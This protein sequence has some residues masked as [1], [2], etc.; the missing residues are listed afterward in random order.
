L[1][2]CYYY[3]YYYYYWYYYWLCLQV[4]WV[5]SDS[6]FS[7]VIQ[8]RSD[9][10][11][12]ST[13]TTTATTFPPDVKLYDVLYDE[14]VGGQ[15]VQEKHVAASR[16]RAAAVAT[17]AVTAAMSV[18]QTPIQKSTGLLTTAPVSKTIGRTKDN[19]KSSASA[20]AISSGSKKK[21]ARAAAVVEEGTTPPRLS[22]A[23]A[24]IPAATKSLTAKLDCILSDFSTA[25]G[26]C[27]DV[28]A[29]REWFT[30]KPI[31]E[32]ADIMRTL[33]SVQAAGGIPE[34]SAEQLCRFFA[35]GLLSG[36]GA[37]PMVADKKRL[38]D[39]FCAICSGTPAADH[40]GGNATTEGQQQQRGRR[41]KGGEAATLLDAP[42]MLRLRAELLGIGSEGASPG[43]GISVGDM[44]VRLW[45]G[46]M[47][48]LGA[49][50]EKPGVNLSEEI[51]EN[52]AST[53]SAAIAY[54]LLVAKLPSV[55]IQPSAQTADEE[56]SVETKDSGSTKAKLKKSKISDAG[57][58]DRLKNILK[59][60]SSFLL[61]ELVRYI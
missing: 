46:G 42:M 54:I 49:V 9:P 17:T 61:D 2:S 44:E 15:V 60:G 57:G 16:I 36:E 50:T 22:A 56:E 39:T 40:A 24:V 37:E 55:G 27:G 31:D 5:E 47:L 4:Y 33:G 48:L 28:V 35:D 52:I 21:K 59:A 14:Q 18:G 7:G 58:T 25:M 34:D 53:G 19:A 29:A 51:L 8:A 3:Y 32:Q 30:V 20:S 13:I 38:R 10:V 45:A 11:S 6:W 12:S 1:W 41:G 43:P 23:E 26:D